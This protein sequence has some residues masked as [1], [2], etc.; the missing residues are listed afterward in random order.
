MAFRVL[1]CFNAIKHE[2]FGS[3]SKEI[4]P[5]SLINEAGEQITNMTDWRWL[6]RPSQQ[7]SLVSG[8][9]Y[10]ALPADFSVLIAVEFTNA[11]PRSLEPASLE[12]VLR[13]RTLF[14]GASQ[15]SY[16]YSVGYALG[17]DGVPAPRL[18]L[19]WTPGTEAN[20]LTVWYVAG[21]TAVRAEMDVI[22][23]PAWMR[24]LFM[25][26]LRAVAAGY[27]NGEQGS[28]TGR[29]LEIE[30][31]PIFQNAVRRDYAIQ[32]N[33]G[34]ILDGLEKHIDWRDAPLLDP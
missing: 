19:N 11:L 28:V 17:A 22:A 33:F 10:V 7:L 26:V 32:P 9:N 8:Q 21:W 15:T 25:A 18:E 2:L 30:R 31:G 3:L 4:S 5:V 24:P 23:V 16:K 13:W 27:E 1:D 12:E 29:L 20:A 6:I 14:P 34:S